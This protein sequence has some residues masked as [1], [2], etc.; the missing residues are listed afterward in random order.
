MPPKPGKKN[1]PKTPGS[2][3]RDVNRNWEAGLTTAQFE[4]V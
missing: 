1:A 3:G 2:A 4:E